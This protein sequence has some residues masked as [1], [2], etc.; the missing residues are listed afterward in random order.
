[1]REYKA[2][3]NDQT[4]F[5]KVNGRTV[6]IGDKQIQIKK[7]VINTLYFET[8]EDSESQSKIF[9][10]SPD[11]YIVNIDGYTME[12]IIQSFIQLDQSD[13]TD[14]NG[15]V[16]SP[17]S[18]VISKISVKLNQIVKEGDLLI[19]ISAMKMENKIVSPVNGKILNINKQ[20][21]E[22]IDPGDLLIVIE[23]DTE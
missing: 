13:N 10:K 8:S 7:K 11:K 2:I 15:Q 9:Q 12:F 18:G 19:V 6:T 4:H 1:M 22:L 16:L 23:L 21:K 20:L 5:V 3:R 17:I 14:E